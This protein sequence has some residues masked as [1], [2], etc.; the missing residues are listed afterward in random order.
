MVTQVQTQNE[1]RPYKFTVDQYHKMGQANILQEDSRVELIEGEIIKMTPI[2][3]KHAGIVDYLLNGPFSQ[4]HKKAIVRVQGPIQLGEY[5]EPEPDLMVLKLRDDYYQT[6]APDQNDVSL[7]VEVSD[8]SYPLDR[9]VKLPLY[10]K[11]EIPEVWI[12]DVEKQ[13][14]E[15]HRTPQDGLYQESKLYKG[16]ETVSSQ[17]IEEIKLTVQEIFRS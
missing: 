3:R 17:I 4:L 8:S 12:I 11:F 6:K 7:I 16:N 13:C 10:A 14:V 5:N 2:G 1:V 15:I 9:Q